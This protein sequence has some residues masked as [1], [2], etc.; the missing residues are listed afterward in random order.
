MMN[1]KTPTNLTLSSIPSG[2]AGIKATLSRM[3]LLTRDGKKSLAIR[4]KAVA[5][6]ARLPQKDFAG[7]VRAIHAFVRDKIRY[8]KDVNG[9]EL[10]HTPEKLLEIGQGDCDDKSMLVASLLEAI[11]HPTR[12]VAISNAPSKFCHVYVETRLGSQWLSVETTENVAVGWQ[13]RAF[14]KLVIHNK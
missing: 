14:E 5:L 8:V 7:E 3:R 13:P 11:G 12:F 10:L 1:L 4:M 9:V 2:V 6:V